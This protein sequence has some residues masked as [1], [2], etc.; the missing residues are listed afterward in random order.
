M[1]IDESTLRARVVARP[2]DDEPRLAYA[3]ALEARG[4]ATGTFVRASVELARLAK[5][6]GTWE[7]E[8][9]ARDALVARL[10]EASGPGYERFVDRVKDA[11]I[12]PRFRRGF[13]EG[14]DVPDPSVLYGAL[15]RMGDD[16]RLVRHLTVRDG[17]V[18]EVIALLGMFRDVVSLEVG[19]HVLSSSG[20]AETLFAS[21][22][23]ARL[24]RLVVGRGSRIEG[25]L[26]A[27]AKRALPRLT[28]LDLSCSGT[29]DAGAKALA[30]ARWTKSLCTLRMS[31]AVLGPEGIRALVAAPHGWENLSTLDLGGNPLG[32]EG[33][34]RLRPL[35][36]PLVVLSL[37]A[38]EADADSLKR[39]LEGRTFSGRKLA[40]LSIDFAAV[41]D[42]LAE[43]IGPKS[44]SLRSLSASSCGV[45]EKGLMALLDL[46]EQSEPEPTSARERAPT[47][48]KKTTASAGAGKAIGATKRWNVS[49]LQTLDLS[50]NPL[51]SLGLEHLAD[52]YWAEKVV[53]LD[54]SFVPNAK[55][56]SKLYLA[57]ALG[58][59]ARFGRDE[60]G[61]RESH[62]PPKSAFLDADELSAFDD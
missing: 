55:K 16:L 45:G 22:P 2:A 47:K 18:D 30:Q 41:G 31:D 25:S 12:S 32:A 59:R 29:G 52:S 57:R 51:G 37:P 36:A 27:L 54:V 53:S 62:D 8:L 13:V 48:A 56:A 21:E 10:T 33:V 42:S 35:R 44:R 9:K 58:S 14:L 50:V 61:A 38:V 39:L 3:A 60:L 43:V 26:K 1:A 49:P 7:A 6:V 20:L 40:R 5:D 19:G 28:M 34:T 24:R 46:L 23:M 11:R 15:E 4:E 17:L